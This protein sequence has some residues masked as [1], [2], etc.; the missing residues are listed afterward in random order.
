MNYDQTVTNIV[1]AAR[2]CADPEE[3]RGMAQ[4]LER[5]SAYREAKHLENRAREIERAF[6][7]MA[8]KR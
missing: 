3:L 8:G 6:A 4:Q 7:E 5:L 2:H 1:N